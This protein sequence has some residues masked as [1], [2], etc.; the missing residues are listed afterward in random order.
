MA[1]AYPFGG[2]WK[3]MKQWDEE[4]RNR[5]RVLFVLLGAGGLLSLI[6]FWLISPILFKNMRGNDQ[7][8]SSMRSK[9]RQPRVEEGRRARDGFEATLRRQREQESNEGDC[10]QRGNQSD[11]LRV[12]LT[13]QVRV[14]RNAREKDE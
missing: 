12:A 1:T 4:E 10:D 8:E 3:G 13:A 11:R 7:A 9:H 14:E 2:N 5:K 6:I